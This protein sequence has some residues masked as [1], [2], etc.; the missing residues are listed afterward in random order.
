MRQPNS[1]EVFSF[2]DLV[3]EVIVDDTTVVMNVEDTL[4]AVLLNH[5][6]DEKEG[7]VE[8]V[9]ST[10]V[11]LQKRKKVIDRL[12]GR[13]FYCFL[14]GYSGY[15]QILIAPEDQEKITFTYPYVA[16]AYLA[17]F[18]S[19][20]ASVESLLSSFGTQ[21]CPIIWHYSQ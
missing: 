21:L 16:A 6:N 10:L 1:N 5:D 4:E 17:S 3:I 9:D 19:S 2:V 18:S 11:V 13:A 12:V 15:N 20:L 14:D 7:F 8:C